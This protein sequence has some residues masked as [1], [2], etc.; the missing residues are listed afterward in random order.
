MLIG[1]LNI[2]VLT[3]RYKES[4]RRY[5]D[6]RKNK[7]EYEHASKLG[8][9]DTKDGVKEHFMTS[10]SGLLTTVMV[11]LTAIAT[12]VGIWLW[13]LILTFYK[14]RHVNTV[15][16][17]FGILGIFMGMFAPIGIILNYTMKKDPITSR[18]E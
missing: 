16:H 12:S 13:N 9:R 15:A 5:S 8:L 17:V 18:T 3:E 14:W 1:P 11:F 6:Y 10:S 2:F 4:F 7:E